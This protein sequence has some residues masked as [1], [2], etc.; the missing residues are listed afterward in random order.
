MKS[1]V[2]RWPTGSPDPV[3]NILATGVLVIFGFLAIAHSQHGVA[4]ERIGMLLVGGHEFPFE[5]RG[6]FFFSGAF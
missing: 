5:I 4:K 1:H 6:P 3:V 2:P